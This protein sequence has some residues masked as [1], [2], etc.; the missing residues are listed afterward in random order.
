MFFL[1]LQ[2]VSQFLKDSQYDIKL[3]AREKLQ[4][5]KEPKVTIKLLPQSKNLLSLQG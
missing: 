1:K 3:C 5:A 2:E 4:T